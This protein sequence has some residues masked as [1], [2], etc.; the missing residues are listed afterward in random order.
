MV[1]EKSCLNTKHLLVK[2]MSTDLVLVSRQ[3]SFDTACWIESSKDVLGLFCNL[4]GVPKGKTE[5][6]MKTRYLLI[7]KTM[8][9]WAHWAT[10]GRTQSTGIFG[11][12]IHCAW[13]DTQG[14]GPLPF[15]WRLD[16]RLKGYSG[17]ARW[18]CWRIS[19]YYY[20]LFLEPSACYANMAVANDPLYHVDL[21]IHL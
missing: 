3:S 20:Q 13:K 10:H 17:S 8:Y 6:S 18:Y 7:Y 9:E 16:V 4:N 15:S 21:I 11:L 14:L 5:T 12:R 2:H 1:L 19:L